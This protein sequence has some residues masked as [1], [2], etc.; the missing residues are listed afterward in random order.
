M[1]AN[2]VP[3]VRAFSNEMSNYPN[4]YRLFLRIVTAPGPTQPELLGYLRACGNELSNFPFTRQALFRA[5]TVGPFSPSD[6]EGI[7]AE[8]QGKFPTFTAMLLR[9]FL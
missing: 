2:P 4:F 3:A 7:V 8:L 5:F 6:V 9:L 1:I